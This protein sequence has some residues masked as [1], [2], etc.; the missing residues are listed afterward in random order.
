LKTNKYFQIRRLDVKFKTQVLGGGG[1][2]PFLQI[3]KIVETTVDDLHVTLESGIR[4][5][6]RN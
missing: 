5:A 2:R 1:T 4:R 6:G 3:Q